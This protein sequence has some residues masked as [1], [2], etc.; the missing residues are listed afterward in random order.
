MLFLAVHTVSEVTA[1]VAF[2]TI[3]LQDLVSTKRV[4][5]EFRCRQLVPTSGKRS[6]SL[7]DCQD[8]EALLSWLNASVTNCEHEIYEVQEDFGLGLGEVSRQRAAERVAAGTRD[9]AKAVGALSMT[10][11]IAGRYRIVPPMLSRL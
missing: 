4:P 11:I 5:P 2:A 1:K 9:V 6:T 10:L 8:P 7:W 3:Q